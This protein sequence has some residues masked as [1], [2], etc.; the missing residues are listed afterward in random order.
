MKRYLMTA[1]SIA[2][3]LIVAFVAIKLAYE[4]FMTREVIALTIKEGRKNEAFND[5]GRLET[6]DSLQDLIR[7][8]CMRE[9]KQLVE[10]QQSVLLSGIAHQMEGNEGVTKVVFERNPE[11]VD[12]ARTEAM[13][14]NPPRAWTL[15]Q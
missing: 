9:A 10:V 1:L 6:F 2:G 12:R 4:P 11:V 15:C 8:G 14:R 5:I 7:R 3:A 13:N